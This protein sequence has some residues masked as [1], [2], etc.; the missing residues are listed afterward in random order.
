MRAAAVALPRTKQGSRL[1]A[2]ARFAPSRRSLLVCAALIALAAGAY[3]VAR[4]TSAFAIGRFD[5]TGAPPDVQR[6]VRRILAPLVGTNLLSLDGAA[7]ERRAESLPT[8]V[9][10][11]Y[12]RAFPHTLRIHVVPEIPVA[13]L[14]RGKE[15]WL[16]SAR[17]RVV[18]H[19]PTGT[20]PALA[21]VWVP[22]KVDV[23][24]GAFLAADT[25]GTAARTL[26]L[27]ARFPAHISTASLAHGELLFRLRSGLELRLGA[28]TDVR[29]KL[30]IARRALAHLPTGATYVDVSVPGRPVAGPDNPQVSSGG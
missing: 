19:I 28:P 15:T 9:S 23:A 11:R 8:V 16:V 4:Q 1:S 10:V 26:A 6:Q 5:V 13:V 18:R 29:L 25:G 21:R 12:D 17:G 27:A 24:V 14:H 22:R 3:T 30:A 2:L 20:Y 7:L